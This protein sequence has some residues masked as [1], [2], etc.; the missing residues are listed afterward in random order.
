MSVRTVLTR[1]LPGDE[2]EVVMGCRQ[3]GEN[4]TSDAD[5]YPN[6]GSDEI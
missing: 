2:T 6:C 5:G 4:L 1:L 3:C